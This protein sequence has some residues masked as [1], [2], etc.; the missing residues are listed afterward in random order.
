VIGAIANVLSISP[1]RALVWAAV[2]NG[3]VAVPVMTLLMR[4][5]V[6]A[7]VM[8]RFTVSGPVLW[9]GWLATGVM[10]AAAI[11]WAASWFMGAAH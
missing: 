7:R 5:A 11:G 8:G 2:I 4:I 3:I 6:N 10:A 1:M 9:L